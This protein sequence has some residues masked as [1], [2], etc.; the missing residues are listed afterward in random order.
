MRDSNEQGLNEFINKKLTES[1]ET[2]FPSDYVKYKIDFEIQNQVENRGEL[3]MKNKFR[4]AIVMCL[5]LVFLGVGGY[6]IGKITGVLSSTTSFY[7]Y[8]NYDDIEKAKKTS[9]LENA[10]VPKSLYSGYEF[11]GI[12]IVDVADVDDSGNEQNMRKSLDITYKNKE[13]EKIYLSIDK[14]VD[15]YDIS[16]DLYKE[17]KQFDG[18][19]FYFS[20]IENLY[21]KPN[22]KLSAEE[23][24]RQKEDPFFNVGYGYAGDGERETVVSTDIVFEDSEMVY[25]ILSFDDVE[26]DEMF[27]IGENFFNK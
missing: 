4:L 3:V 20:R 16:K 26:S 14:K 10:F 8:K 27:K 5:C 13:N 19:N 21:V 15:S 12:N 9:G 25:S 24:K 22:A 1:T 18:R 6:A 2:L 23:E 17:T 7:T 11:D